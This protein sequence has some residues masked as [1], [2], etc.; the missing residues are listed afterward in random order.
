MSI[1]VEH[2]HPLKAGE[3]L[4][5]AFRLY[6]ANFWIFISTATI[7][8]L[9]FLVAEL[10]LEFFFKN[11]SYL[12]LLELFLIGNVLNGAMVW[13]AS[14][15]YLGYRLSIWDSYWRSL[16]RFGVFL[17]T[18]LFLVGAYLLRTGLMIFVAAVVLGVIA[19]VLRMGPMTRG[20]EFDYLTSSI[21]A[22]IN[23]L[24]EFITLILLVLNY[25]I[26]STQF[27]LAIVTI[28]REGVGPKAFL[29]RSRELTSKYFWHTFIVAVGSVLL[30]F[31]IVFL[32][33][34]FGNYTVS[35]LQIP[36]FGEMLFILFLQLGFVMSTPLYASIQVILYYDLRVRR[37]GY[38]F[39]LVLQTGQEAP[40]GEKIRG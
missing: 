36:V 28:L 14:Q 30:C 5:R 34:M 40:Q 16:R 20:S 31:G 27:G 2:L 18:N 38:D 13:L 3:I 29:R 35:F 7:F 39:E 17:L 11:T 19:F 23:L 21:V 26:S 1:S 12:F 8:L 4:D 9:P 32:P 22:W 10:S 15:A 33:S 37:E 24:G 25:I 6:R